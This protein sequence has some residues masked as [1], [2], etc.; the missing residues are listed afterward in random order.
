MKVIINSQYTETIASNGTGTCSVTFGSSSELTLNNVAKFFAQN[1]KSINMN[2]V[3]QGVG[4]FRVGAASTVNFGPTSN[5]SSFTGGF[6][7][8]GNNSALNVNTAADGTFLKLGVSIAPDEVSLGHVITVNTA[9]VLKG[10]I[11]ILGNPVNLNINANQSAVGTITMTSG[12]LILALGSD[13]SSLVFA[14]NSAS[15]WGSGTLEITDFKDN[16]ISF[17]SDDQ[18]L[19]TTQLSQINIG[20]EIVK[21]NDLGNIYNGAPPTISNVTSSLSDGSYTAGDTIPINIIFNEVV[22][23]T[24]TPVLELETGTSDVEVAYTSGTGTDILTFNYT[25]AADHASDDL[26]YVGSGSLTGIDLIKDIVGNSAT[27][28]LPEP[29]ATGSLGANKAFVIDNTSPTL[30]ITATEGADGFTS[31]DSILS[32]I[33]TISEAT[34]DFTVEDITATG[35]IISDFVSVSGTVY[36]ATLTPSSE[37]A[38]TIDVA[39]ATFK[40]AVGNFNAV[41]E[42]FNWTYDIS[43]VTMTI[44]AA[45]G[46][47]GFMSEDSVLSLTFTTNK[48]TSDFTVD[49]ITVTGGVI[50]N[51][52]SV[53]ST[54]YTAMFTPSDEGAIT[55]DVG[56][57]AFE[58]NAGNLNIVALQFN[59]TFDIKYAPELLDAEFTIPENSPNGTVIGFIEASDAD[60]D[61]LSYTIVSGN[62]A[63]AFSLDSESGELIVLK[64][65]ELDFETTPIYSL[66]IS[67]SDEVLIDSATVIINLT[68]VEEFTL[69][70]AEDGQMIYPNPSSGII[71]I[72]LNQF[73]K[74]ELYDL[75]GK[76]VLTSMDRLMDISSI[77]KGVYLINI[78]RQDGTTSVTKIIK[79]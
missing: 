16:I 8:L 23:V 20:G 40:D 24:G 67:V 18:G 11:S 43:A 79:K 53:S 14:N 22:N 44:T 69:S 35:G 37:G 27:L 65:S 34:T 21:I 12:T 54:V 45:E 19:S 3:L 39:A 50:S 38:L 63:E 41:A 4:E 59:W 75:S 15:D 32:L 66:G 42:Q 10:N 49:D 64:S 70:L 31:N 56:A 76:K 17:G 29:G 71:N 5:N 33:F 7:I 2:G 25:V 61:T 55:I 48:P 26:D 74:A 1:N 13:V 68:D 51:F 6:K 77:D 36:T 52:I 58:D 72:R 62:D 9:N 78:E 60:G 57:G 28:T 30:V 46:L 73:K 47:D